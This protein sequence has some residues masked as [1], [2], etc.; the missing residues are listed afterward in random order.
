MQLVA[1]RRDDYYVVM[2]DCAHLRTHLVPC[3]SSPMMYARERKKTP[4]T[5]ENIN[6]IGAVF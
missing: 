5:Y 1:G 2:R 6:K 4:R 3:W